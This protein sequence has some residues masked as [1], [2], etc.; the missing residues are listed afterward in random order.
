MGEF[1]IAFSKGSVVCAPGDYLICHRGEGWK[2][3]KVEDLLLVKRLVPVLTDPPELLIEE[4]ALDSMTPAYANEV[5]FLVTLFDSDFDDE[6]AALQAI[7][8]QTLTGRTKGLLRPAREFPE[9]DCQ[10]V[11]RPDTP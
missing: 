1:S 10:V 4:H 6:S 2:V 7:H 5:Q 8:Q 11:H 9:L 3:Y